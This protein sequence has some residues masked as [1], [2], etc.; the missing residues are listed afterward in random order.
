MCRRVRALHIIDW[1]RR[2][3]QLGYVAKIRLVGWEF[4]YLLEAETHRLL[5]LGYIAKIKLMRRRVS[6]LIIDWTRRLLQLGYIAKIR[7]VWCRAHAFII[8]WT[9]RLMLELGYLA[10]LKLMCQRVCALIIDWTRRLLQL[11][12]RFCKKLLL[13]KWNSGQLPISFI[14]IRFSCN[15]NIGETLTQCKKCVSPIFWL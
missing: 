6:A 1:T 5:Q 3:L 13:H 15:Q 7:L 8:N 10:K 9:R 4:L 14:K 11:K 12:S 2:L